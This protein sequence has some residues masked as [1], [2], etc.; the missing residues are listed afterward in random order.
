MLANY[1]VHYKNLRDV[2]ADFILLED[3]FTLMKKHSLDKAHSY[4]LLSLL[5]DV[6][7]QTFHKDVFQYIRLLIHRWYRAPA[8]SRDI[9]LC[10]PVMEKIVKPTYLLLHFVSGNHMSTKTIGALCEWL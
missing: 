2:Q 5:V 7:L 4:A 6:C 3:Y 1:Q 8:L 9:A 10:G